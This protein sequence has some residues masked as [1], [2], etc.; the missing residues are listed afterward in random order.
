MPSNATLNSG[1]DVN[2]QQSGNNGDSSVPGRAQSRIN[3]TNDG[4]EHINDRHLDP[5]VNAS[6]FSI[7]ESDLRNVL[8][9]PKTIST[10]INREMPSADGVRY[11]REV[12]VGKTI[13]TDKYNNGQPTSVMTVLTDKYG[14]LVTAFPGKLK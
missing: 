5:S 14:N 7:S 4:M 12:D 13:G 6:Q 2:G 8:Q 3:V 9:D 10:P 1:N 11:A